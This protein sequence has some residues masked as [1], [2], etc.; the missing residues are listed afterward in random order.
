MAETKSVAAPPD[1][2]P[3]GPIWGPKGSLWG[4]LHLGPFWAATLLASAILQAKKE[5][6][7][8]AFLSSQGV[9]HE[10]PKMFSFG[11]KP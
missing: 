7:L 5:E 6:A 2:G 4:H 3:K 8:V 9:S 1:Q 10:P 11:S